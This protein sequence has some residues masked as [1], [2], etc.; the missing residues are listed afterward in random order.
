MG[1]GVW[2]PTRL[3]LKGF[4]SFPCDF[5]WIIFLRAEENVVTLISLLNKRQEGRK[6]SSPSLSNLFC[7]VSALFTPNL[8]QWIEE[9]LQGIERLQFEKKRC[10]GVVFPPVANLEKSSAI[11]FL[12]KGSFYPRGYFVV[13]INLEVTHWNSFQAVQKKLNLWHPENIFNKKVN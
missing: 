4:G 8:T 10:F 2:G 6:I 12:C 7:R 3:L 1:R 11:G 9:L 13:S 5:D